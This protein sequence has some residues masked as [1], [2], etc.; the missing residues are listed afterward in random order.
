MDPTAFSKFLP[1]SSL[2]AMLGGVLFSGKVLWDMMIIT[3]LHATDVT[4]HLF[5][6][7]PLFLLIGM[8]GFCTLCAQRYGTLGKMGCIIS[9]SGLAVGTIG[10]LVGVWVE[11]LW[12]AYWLG[13]RFLCIGLVLLGVATIKAQALPGGWSALPLTLGLL[14]LGRTLFMF[15]A[16]TMGFTGLNAPEAGDELGTFLSSWAGTLTSMLG[17]LFGLGWLCLGYALWAGKTEGI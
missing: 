11:P 17:L 2:A 15:F 4:D 8:A 14:G 13:F 5:F 3:P 10:S 6:F 9:L 1:W 7:A 16:V 12:L